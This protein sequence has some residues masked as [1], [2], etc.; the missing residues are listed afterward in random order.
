MPRGRPTVEMLA[1]V[2]AVFA[3]QVVGGVLGWTGLFVLSTPLSANPW[4]IV[5][6]VYAHA[7]PGHLVA[8]V[9][10]LAILGPLVARRTSRVGFHAYF[11]ATGALAGVAEV[12]VGSLVGPPTAVVGASGAIFALLGYMLA[13]NVVSTRLLDWISL[14]RRATLVLFLAIA[15]LV[16]LATGSP[17]AALVGH[18]TGLGLGLLAGRARLLDGGAPGDLHTARGR[19]SDRS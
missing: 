15:V 8:N 7:G 19:E 13:G 6:H 9:V 12:T 10:G 14:S 11:L 16:T 1:V 17:R 2:L 5:T 18:A 3:L 4:T